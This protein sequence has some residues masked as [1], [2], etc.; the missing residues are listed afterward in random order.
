MDP[1]GPA[2]LGIA[3]L[4]W[5]MLAGSS[6]I[7]AVVL[8]LFAVLMLR[9]EAGRRIPARR[10]IVWGG[11]ALPLPVILAVTGT[12][13]WQGEALRAGPPA[14]RIEAEAYMWGWRFAYPPATGLP[15]TEGVLHLP[16]GQEVEMVVT[17]P[18]VIHSF[19]IPRLGGKIDAIPGHANTL[20]L[21][22]DAP[23]DYGGVC[24]EYCGIGHVDMSF[25]ARAHAIWPPEDLP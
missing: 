25:T 2:A 16:A 7:F 1:A 5:A 12:A 11:I 4:W 20:R 24:A 23:G 21:R 6:L 9:P 19:W 3:R 18:D 8:T 17:S 14:L 13:L 22:A 10:W 15:P